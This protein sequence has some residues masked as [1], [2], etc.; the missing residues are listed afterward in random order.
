MAGA[1]PQ[2]EWYIARDGQQYGPLS[3]L[4]MRKFVELGHLRPTDLVWRHGFPDWRPAPAVFPTTAPPRPEPPRPGYQPHRPAYQG[5]RR[6]GPVRAQGTPAR[7]SGLYRPEPARAATAP[8][9][10]S[11]TC[12]HDY[13]D[14]DDDFDDDFPAERPRR[15]FRGIVAARVGVAL[16]S[17]LL[18]L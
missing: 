15:G 3:D 5:R 18:W 17:G 4:E 11:E 12:E 7:K 8:V 13:G 9:A 2:I 14:E 16:L 10:V 1:D 6:E